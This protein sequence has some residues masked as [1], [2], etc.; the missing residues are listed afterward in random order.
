MVQGPRGSPSRSSSSTSRISPSGETRLLP[1][2]PRISARMRS[3]I[4][5]SGP[6]AHERHG[7]RGQAGW[8][9][10]RGRR[11]RAARALQNCDLAE[12]MADPKPDLP[13]DERNLNFAG[14][15]EV[16]GTRRLAAANDNGPAST[17]CAR[18]NRIM[19]A[20]C[21]ALSSANSGTLA[22][23]P[24]VTTKSRRWICSAKAVA[25]MPTGSAAMMRP[26]KIVAAS[27]SR[28]SP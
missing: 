13:L 8:C 21:P 10:R 14:G 12:E 27:M 28:P 19:S 7:H 9:G 18:I 15:D 6:S 4:Q 5:G 17:V 16:H 20:I 11:R 26:V 3:A 2:L 24:Q 23:I 1:I 22:T 25:T